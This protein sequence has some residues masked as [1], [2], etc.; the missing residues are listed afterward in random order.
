MHDDRVM[1]IARL[2]HASRRLSR[3]RGRCCPRARAVFAVG[4]ARCILDGLRAC[5]ADNDSRSSVQGFCS[6]G[7]TS[8]E[9][10]H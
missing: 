1:V 9:G 8:R 3:P 2:C 10:I 6:L 7:I 4:R 5:Y